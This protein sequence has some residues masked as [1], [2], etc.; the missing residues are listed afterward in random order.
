MTRSKAQRAADAR[1]EK[2]RRGLPSL[3]MRLTH[4]QADWLDDRRKNQESRAAALRRL[5]GMPE[6]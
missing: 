1:Y 3:S 4:E 2:K 5:A 6:Q